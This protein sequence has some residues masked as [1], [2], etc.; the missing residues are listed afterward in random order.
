MTRLKHQSIGHTLGP[1][2][3]SKGLYGNKDEITIWGADEIN[4]C[5]HQ[6]HGFV[7]TLGNQQGQDEANALLIAAA[8]EMLEAL[9]DAL[10]DRIGWPERIAKVIAKAKGA[11]HV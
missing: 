10:S 6:V 5:G 1:W 3:A 4:E 9:E 2:E 7:A 11:S 8:P